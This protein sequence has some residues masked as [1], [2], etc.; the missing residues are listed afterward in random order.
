MQQLCIMSPLPF[1]HHYSILVAIK[2]M[3]LL[4]TSTSG[5]H[6]Y[7]IRSKNIEEYG[8]F[9]SPTKS[10]IQRS[11][12]SHILKQMHLGHFLFHSFWSIEAYGILGIIVQVIKGFLFSMMVQKWIFIIPKSC[13]ILFAIGI[14]L[15]LMLICFPR[16]T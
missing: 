16:K 10:I 5:I 2:R 1:C 6:L 15:M 14:Q 3:Q 13:N 8:E 9:V 11:K 7:T 4:R 12:K